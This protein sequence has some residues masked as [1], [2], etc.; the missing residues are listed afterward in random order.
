MVL[1]GLVRREE[2]TTRAT[3]ECG[4]WTELIVYIE[5]SSTIYT[6]EHGKR[7]AP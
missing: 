5:S 3:I 7:L 2:L 4:W 1:G 6:R